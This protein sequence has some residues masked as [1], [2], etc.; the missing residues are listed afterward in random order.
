MDTLAKGLLTEAKIYSALVQNGYPVVFPARIT[1]WDIGW[2][3]GDKL[4][5]VQC[6]TGIVRNGAVM[7]CTA[8]RGCGKTGRR[9]YRNQVDYFGVYVAELEKVYLIPVEAVGTA[10]ATLRLTPS[11]N[12]QVK[13]I[14]WAVDYEMKKSSFLKKIK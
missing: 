5:R 10:T 4:I 3:E 8:S 12:S 6:K 13:K 7:F 9:H 2:E 14:K 1:R 11:R